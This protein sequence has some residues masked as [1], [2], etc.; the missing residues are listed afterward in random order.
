MI[1]KYELKNMVFFLCA[2]SGVSRSGYYNYFSSESQERR[3]QR[4]KK[5][6]ILKVNIIKAFQFK[7]RKKGARQIK[8]TLEGQFQI[9]YNLKRIRRIMR[10]YKIVCPIR[11]TN[12][13][14]KMLKATQEHTVLPN[15]LN[16]EFK[17][18]IPGKVLLTD[19]S[20]NF[21]FPF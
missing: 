5:D 10:K 8:M 7:R 18:A 9:T 14:Q 2:I 4:E 1:E 13:Y 17:Q 12:P 6:L 11:R 21:L 20:Y 19:T 15:L 3:K 16:R